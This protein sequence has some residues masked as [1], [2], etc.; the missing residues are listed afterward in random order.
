MLTQPDG[1]TPEYV[2]IGQGILDDLGRELAL[3]GVEPAAAFLIGDESVDA[4]YGDR[5]ASALEEAGW[6]VWRRTVP[7]GEESKSV[8]AAEQLWQW[9]LRC[10]A[11]RSDLIVAL[12]GGVVGDLAGFVA[13]TWGRGI[14]WA[15]VA[16]TLLAQVDSSI[17]GK[18]AVDLPGGKNMVGSFHN[19][20][21]SLLDTLTLQT[22]PQRD[23]ASG[24]VEAIKHG[25]IR[26]AAY[27]AELERAPFDLRDPEMLELAVRNSVRIKSEVVVNDPFDRGLRAVLNYG[28]TV[29]HAIETLGQY[30]RHRHGEAVAIGMAAAGYIS[31]KLTGLGN[32]ELERQNALLKACGIELA[33]SGFAA[34]EV[35]TAMQADKK[36]AGG[37]PRWVL[38]EELGTASAG[39]SVDD[40][41][42]REALAAIGI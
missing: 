2:A 7:A 38:L 30:R 29:G 35:V 6:R 1:Y 26:D 21:L 22:L 13:A 16:T 23:L 24:W 33:A 11:E 41:L 3:R 32:D 40:T 14:A 18:V 27:L 42:V 36:S 17:G 37:R 12:G 39:H 31:T 15:Q 25:L 20:V 34:A 19:P 5:V 9:L 4:H 8:A 10:R 28:H